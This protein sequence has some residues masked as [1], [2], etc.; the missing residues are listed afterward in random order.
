MSNTPS[1]YADWKAPDQDGQML[2]WPDVSALLR[3][4]TENRRALSNSKILIQNIPLGELRRRQRASIGHANDDQPLIATGHQTELY[5]S[6]VWVKDALTN[7]VARKVGGVAWHFAVDT[8][9]PKHLYLRWPGGSMA[10]TDDPDLNASAWTGLL[11]SPAPAYVAMIAGA[12]E[13]AQSGWDFEPM[14]GEFLAALKTAAKEKF[15]L[16]AGMTSAIQH[17]DARLGLRSRAL[18]ISPVWNAEPYLV[19]AHHLLARAGQFAAQYNQALA[20]YRRQQGV[21]SPGRPMPDLVIGANEVETP[22]WLD[23]LDEASRQRLVL[24]KIEGSW[25]F[26]SGG[27]TLIFHDDAAGDQA[28]RRLI[29]FLQNHRLRIAPRALTLTMFFRMLLADQYVHGIGGGRYD[30]VTDRIIASHF[31]IEPPRFSVTTATL[32]FP[33][34]R[35]QKHVSLRPLLQEGRRLRHG[36]FWRE[37]RDLADRIATLPRRSRERQEL[38]YQMHASLGRQA[39]SEVLREWSQRLDHAT[40]EQMR[41]KTLFDRELF[42]AIQPQDRLR[43]MISRYDAAIDAA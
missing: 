38:F 6:G 7:A 3:Q 19:F 42:Y 26:T 14:A 16:A 32:F 2:L 23:N 22:F 24:K 25:A 9:S 37:K 11:P 18:L 21:T 1:R 29:D 5:H 17:L 39:S 30:Q 8:D 43:E 13:K 10:I 27:D 4:T 20:D 28:A 15:P 31:G 40:K 34:A 35:G 12:L 33:A 36:S 41:Q